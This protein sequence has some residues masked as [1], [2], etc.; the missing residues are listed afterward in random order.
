M[1]FWIDCGAWFYMFEWC[2]RL[3]SFDIRL[4][5]LRGFDDGSLRDY[6][7]WIDIDVPEEYWNVLDEY[8]SDPLFELE[9]LIC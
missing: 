6:R 3:Y 2:G 7:H 9:L 4:K 5:E 8:F 1:N